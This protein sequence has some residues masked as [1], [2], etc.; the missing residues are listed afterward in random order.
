MNAL[1]LA[2]AAAN[3]TI[4]GNFTMCSDGTT[5]WNN[6]NNI[7]QIRTPTG[8]ITN[9]YQSGNQIRIVPSY[10]SPVPVVPVQPMQPLVPG[11]YPVR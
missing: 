3:C 11:L 8:E 10:Q 4:S 2:L 6:G 5:V 1:I 9:V 7:S